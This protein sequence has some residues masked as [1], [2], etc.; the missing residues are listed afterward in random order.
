MEEDNIIVGHVRKALQEYLND[1][2]GENPVGIR[3]MV[4]T[5]VEKPVIEVILSH[6]DGN[7]T[8]AAAMLGVNI[9][10]VG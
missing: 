3:D 1:L 8:K 2:D 6:V 5:A 9:C 4:I 10:S 7:Q